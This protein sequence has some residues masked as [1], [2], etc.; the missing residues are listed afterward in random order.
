MKNKRQNYCQV[1]NNAI[2]KLND[3]KPKIKYSTRWLYIYL[4]LLEHRFAGQNEDF[5]FRSIDDIQKDIHMG[6]R[7]V[8]SGIKTLEALSLIHT[9]QMH[10]VDKVTK[11]KSEK[12][13]T[14]FRILNV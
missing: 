6:R 12:H 8:I 14:A 3:Y 9:W 10:W 7:Q 4:N 1:Y 11:K 5:F 13:I 2:K